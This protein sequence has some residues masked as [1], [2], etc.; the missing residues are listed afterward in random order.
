MEDSTTTADARTYLTFSLAEEVFA[1]DVARVREVR[2]LDRVTKIPRT[3][4]FVRGVINLRGSV[5]PV[6]DMRVKFD[7]PHAEDTV[8]TCVVVMEMN[9]ES[10]VIGALAD[11]VRE[12]FDLDQSEIEPPSSIGAKFEEEYLLGVGKQGSEFILILDVEKVFSETERIALSMDG[13]GTT[14]EETLEE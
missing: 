12:V 9:D 11:S 10:M 1:V 13:K 4:T 7:L 3:P 2:D 6:V 5:V 14:V 8:D